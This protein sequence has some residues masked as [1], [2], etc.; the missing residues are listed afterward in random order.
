MK[1]N[2]TPAEIQGPVVLEFLA[3]LKSALRAFSPS[4]ADD[5][6]L[7]MEAGLPEWAA[8]AISEGVRGVGGEG[9]NLDREVRPMNTAERLDRL[10]EDLRRKGD[11]MAASRVLR[12]RNRLPVGEARVRPP[13]Q[14]P[15]R[16]AFEEA[17]EQLDPVRR[18][19]FERDCRKRLFEL[20]GR[21]PDGS[22]PP[23][24]AL[25]EAKSASD[26][27]EFAA[28]V[29]RALHAVSPSGAE[30]IRLLMEAGFSEEVARV[31]S[32]EFR[33][34]GGQG[35]N[36]NCGARP[37]TAADRLNRLYEDLRRKGDDVAASKVLR[38][39]NRLPVS[40]DR[41][42]PLTDHV[43]MKLPRSASR[44]AL[45][46]LGPAGRWKFGRECTQKLFKLTGPLPNG[47]KLPASTTPEAKS[48]SDRV[49]KD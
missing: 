33:G 21:L 35:R 48:A 44:E 45:E 17:S 22:K 46:E 34:A 18:R 37:V 19:Q 11:D 14:K 47:S 49:P 8:L 9:R 28:E 40:E 39:Q 31:T 13:T 26:I 24:S 1:K 7:L 23:T 3:E 42:Q 10:F 43:R 4:G 16:A 27:A 29:E 12:E 20:T 6:R 32:E 25:P 30:D 5:I 15:P 38:E 41:V 36:S 2:K